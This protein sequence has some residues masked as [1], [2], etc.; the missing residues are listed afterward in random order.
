VGIVI[1]IRAETDKKLKPETVDLEE[2]C[3]QD[4]D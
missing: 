2:N 4:I 1:H 3:V